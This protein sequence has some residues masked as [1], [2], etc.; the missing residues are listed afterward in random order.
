MSLTYWH[1]V[2]KFRAGEYKFPPPPGYHG[3]W[4]RDTWIHY[5]DNHGEWL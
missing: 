5:I 4:D 3:D 2:V 1:K